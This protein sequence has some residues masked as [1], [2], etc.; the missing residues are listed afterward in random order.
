MYKNQFWFNPRR[1][2]FHICRPLL[3]PEFSGAIRVALYYSMSTLIVCLWCRRVFCFLTCIV[4]PLGLVNKPH[5]IFYLQYT[6]LPAANNPQFYGLSHPILLLSLF[7][8]R[9]TVILWGASC[10]L[11]NWL[12]SRSS[13]Y[14]KMEEEHKVVCGQ[15]ERESLSWSN[16]LANARFDVY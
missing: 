6:S 3:F 8:Q 13:F 9:H 2:S 4:A 10:M 15:R 14:H 1:I 12:M 7:S 11:I 5:F 16:G